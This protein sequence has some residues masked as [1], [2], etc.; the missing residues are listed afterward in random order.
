MRE[1]S[2]LQAEHQAGRGTGEGLRRRGGAARRPRNPA[3]GSRP[4]RRRWPSPD[5]CSRPF[6][7]VPP[8]GARGARPEV[9]PGTSQTA[10]GALASCVRARGAGSGGWLGSAAR[11]LGFADRPA[12]TVRPGRRP[13]RLEGS[14]E[15]RPG[16]GARRPPSR[17]AVERRNARARDAPRFSV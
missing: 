2:E 13:D 8:C 12:L 5:A 15:A 1:G 10:P 11:V 14:A 16:L 6:P 7:A 9:L 3:E 4:R 17:S